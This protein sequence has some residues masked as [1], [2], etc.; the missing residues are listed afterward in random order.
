M[1]Q[2]GE[3]RYLMT[4]LVHPAAI[5]RGQWELEPA[6]IAYLRRVWDHVKAGTEP[7]LTDIDQPPPGAKLFPSVEDLRAVVVSSQMA[8]AVSI[9]I[10]NAGR[11]L[12][13]VGFTPLSLTQEWWVGSPV[14]LRFRL[15][16][17][18]QFWRR[19][20]DLEEVIELVGELLADTSV[21][22]VFHNAL[23]DVSI[24]EAHGWPVRG[25]IIDTMILAHL[26]YSEQPKA[27]GFCAT[28]YLGAP[29]WKKL[30]K[31]VEEED[32]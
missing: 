28:L 18:A 1:T 32:A 10:E 26:C 25:R 8:G 21:A 3:R 24:L 13:C 15:R 29:N 14:C 27:L 19:D 2:G 12:I 22:K 30:V 23:H 7:E 31:E 6:Q 5:V 17:G 9:D 4:P 20:S 16:G 11:F